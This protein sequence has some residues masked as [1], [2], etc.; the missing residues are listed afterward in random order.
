LVKYNGRSGPTKSNRRHSVAAGALHLG[1][2]TLAPTSRSPLITVPTDTNLPVV[3]RPEVVTYVSRFCHTGR[4]DPVSGVATTDHR[5]RIGPPE[6]WKTSALAGASQAPADF[7]RTEIDS[8]TEAF[9]RGRYSG[10]VMA[11]RPRDLPEPDL[12]FIEDGLTDADRDEAMANWLADFDARPAIE[13]AV[14]ASDVLAEARAEGE[15]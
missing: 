7:P 12:T 13:I 8:S 1:Q 3:F 6:L 15:I 5:S 9:V 10:T 4:P 2:A 11:R 14:R